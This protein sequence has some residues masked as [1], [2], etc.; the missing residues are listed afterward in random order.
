MPEFRHEASIL[1][2]N[3][4]WLRPERVFERIKRCAEERRLAKREGRLCRKL[5][6]LPQ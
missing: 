3:A 1:F 6:G 5:R 4:S 2:R